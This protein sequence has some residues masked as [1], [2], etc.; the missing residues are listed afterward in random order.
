MPRAIKSRSSKRIGYKRRQSPRRRKKSKQRTSV[1]SDED[2]SVSDED[3]LHNVNSAVAATPPSER[4]PSHVSTDSTPENEDPEVED[5]F[6]DGS[7]VTWT[8]SIEGRGIRR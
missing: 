5:D 2:C 6:S 7:D 8:P 1:S 4:G 3:V